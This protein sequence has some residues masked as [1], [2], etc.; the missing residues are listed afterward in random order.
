MT[1]V[2]ICRSV[3]KKCKIPEDQ[4]R[5][6]VDELIRTAVDAMIEGDEVKLRGL[7][8]LYS[9]S[10][11]VWK[12]KLE[13]GTTSEGGERRRVRFRPFD[14]TNQA[15]TTAWKQRQPKRK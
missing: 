6:V 5:R 11:N 14:S 13:F 12:G 10:Y 4:A 1:H 15:I 9:K 7:G 2:E 8:V 3:A